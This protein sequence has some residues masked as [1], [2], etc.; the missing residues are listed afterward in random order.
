MENF[1]STIPPS[2]L[3]T[4]KLDE[5]NY[6]IWRMQISAAIGGYGLE[7]F[8]SGASAVPPRFT[9]EE[10]ERLGKITAE[11]LEWKEQDQLLLSWIL[12]VWET[13]LDF[14]TSQSKSKIIWFRRQLRDTKKG[15]MSMNEY[16][17][18]IK[19][20]VDH[21]NFYGNPVSESDHIEAIFE[22]LP[23]EY[24]ALVVSVSVLSGLHP[25]SV[26]DLEC[27]LIEQE[28]RIERRSKATIE[29]VST[30]NVAQSAQP[31]SI[32]RNSENARGS[33]SRG[34]Y[35]GRNSIGFRGGRRGR[36]DRSYG[37]WLQVTCQLCGEVGHIAHY[38]CHRYD[39]SYQ[40]PQ[41]A[42]QLTGPETVHDDHSWYA[43]SGTTN[44]ISH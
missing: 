5:G 10:D 35:S 34:R 23:P 39:R 4:I 12:L 15:A 14:F 2:F 18:K 3:I 20:A 25:Y 32:D 40:G 7:R 30:V 16:L 8:I 36:S 21:L 26:T 44:H 41:A 27:L 9:S 1:Q 33:Y 13:I 37:N 22:G 31:Q 6:L 28:W 17:L 19:I 24:D 11:F 38:C 42:H 29:S 43:E